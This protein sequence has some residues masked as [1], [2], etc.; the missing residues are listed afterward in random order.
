MK[1]PLI[2]TDQKTEYFFADELPGAPVWFES[3]QGE[4][5][6]LRVNQIARRH[7][8]GPPADDPGTVPG[9]G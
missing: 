8:A 9:Q 3:R 4:R 2:R 1:E 7:L 5:V 6:L